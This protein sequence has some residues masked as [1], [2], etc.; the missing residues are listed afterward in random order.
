MAAF[1]TLG[2]LTRIAVGP[3]RMAISLACLVLFGGLIELSQ[4]VI[5]GQ[6]AAEW[7]DVIANAGGAFFG[8]GMASIVAGIFAMLGSDQ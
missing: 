5:G 6:H 7:Q 4:A 1:A 2:V 8:I 3:G